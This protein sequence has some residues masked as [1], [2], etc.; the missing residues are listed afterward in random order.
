[1]AIV[2]CVP[3]I[4]EGRRP[5]VVREVARAVE[6]THGARL[7]DYSSD[8][9]HNRSVFTF[10]GSP[11]A[12]SRAALAL[13]DVALSHIDMRTHAGAHPRIGAVDVIPFVPITGVS[14]DECVALAREVAATV[15]REH[16]VPVY[17]YAKAATRPERVRLPDIRKPQYEGLA[18]LI[19]GDWRPD[20]GPAKVH[21]KSGAIVVGARPPLIAF[22]MNLR[23]GDLAL[24]KRI[25]KEIRESSGG[26]PAVQAMGVQLG[27]GR[28][29][30]SMNLLDFT[31]TPLSVLWDAVE[32]RAKAAGVE[33][34]EGEL[35]GLMPLDAGLEV[36][37]SKLRLR[38]F[39]RTRVIEAHFLE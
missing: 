7:L 5:E 22:N 13:V 36:A 31:V 38:G 25:S 15:A 35:I 6:S 34:D 33:V 16:D 28:A 20:F 30:V 3:N 8:A 1:M 37:A 26:M 10:A 23:S 11:E 29:Q 14:M 32:S 17:L 24:A 18:A 4:S 39:A 9:D 27:D 12:V 19:E 2:E 21:P